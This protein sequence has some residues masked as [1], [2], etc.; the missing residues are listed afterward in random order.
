[1]RFRLHAGLAGKPEQSGEHKT[2]R[3]AK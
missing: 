3:D 2:E 1:L